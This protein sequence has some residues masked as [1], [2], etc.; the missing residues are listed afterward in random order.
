MR[1][2]FLVL[3]PTLIASCPPNTSS[4]TSVICRLYDATQKA[5][6]SNVV[7][8][9]ATK[10]GSF[11]SYFSPKGSSCELRIEAP[12]IMGRRTV[13]DYN[14]TVRFAH[15]GA[16]SKLEFAACDE[17]TCTTRYQWSRVE[18]NVAQLPGTGYVFEMR[19]VAV[20]K[21]SLKVG[22]SASGPNTFEL[23]WTASPVECQPCQEEDSDPFVAHVVRCNPCM[24]PGSRACWEARMKN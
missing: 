11:A 12:M 1:S 14:L 18:W 5:V 6:V 20:L 19:A 4:H 17:D 7:K 3:L 16:E 10:Y 13:A 22:E 8:V 24:V 23:H 2:A 15:I 21:L 9:P